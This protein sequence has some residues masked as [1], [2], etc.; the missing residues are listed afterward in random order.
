MY[1][2]TNL[3]Q[4]KRFITGDIFGLNSFS[5]TPL[6]VVTTPSSA[7]AVNCASDIFDRRAAVPCGTIP[8]LVIT[9]IMGI[10]VAEIHLG[11][12]KSHRNG[13]IKHHLTD[14]A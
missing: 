12:R 2:I 11:N 13:S 4:L 8:A 5:F 1:F 6:V 10:L 7:A 9:P 14:E 3:Q